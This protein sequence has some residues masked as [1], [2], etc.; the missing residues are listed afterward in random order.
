MT[1][2][3][4]AGISFRDNF[5]QSK[6]LKN[7]CRF[8]SS[9]SPSPPPKRFRGSFTNNLHIKSAT[10]LPNAVINKNYLKR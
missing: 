6:F 9:A 5:F 2:L 8:S 7:G 3:N 1:G 4:G 10:S